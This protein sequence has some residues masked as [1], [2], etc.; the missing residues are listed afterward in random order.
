MKCEGRKR[1]KEQILGHITDIDIRRE[2]KKN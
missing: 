1:K 2:E